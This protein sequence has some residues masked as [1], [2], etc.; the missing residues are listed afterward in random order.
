LNNVLTV[1]YEGGPGSSRPQQRQPNYKA[2]KP[3]ALE[4]VTLLKEWKVQAFSQTISQFSTICF[5][6]RG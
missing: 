1:Q 5:N 3:Q 2:Q 4:V 6:H